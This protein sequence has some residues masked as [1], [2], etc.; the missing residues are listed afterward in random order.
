[1]ITVG[2]G[3]CKTCGH[4]LNDIPLTRK[5]LPADDGGTWWKVEAEQTCPHCGQRLDWMHE[6][7]IVMERP[8]RRDIGAIL[9]RTG[10]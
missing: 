1:M 6:G 5:T 4:A 3:P 2:T 10:R 7:P 9:E 8:A